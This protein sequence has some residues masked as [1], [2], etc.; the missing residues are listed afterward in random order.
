MK[1]IIAAGI[2]GCGR[3]EYLAGWLDY[4]QSAGRNVKVFN[5]GELMFEHAYRIGIELSREN[6]LNADPDLL[7]VLRSAVF[8]GIMAELS[9][10]KAQGLDSA[11]VCIHGFFFWKRRFQRSYDRFLNYFKPD[12][13]V[14]FIDDFRNISTRLSSRP[15]WQKEE[16]SHAEVL[17]WQNVEVEVTS[18]LAEFAEK[19]F[20]T[21]PTGQPTSTLY[22]LV[23]HPEIEPVYVAA[24]ISH[25]R[26]PEERE[27]ID[28]FIAG[29]DRYFT[30]FNP[31]TVEIIG[32]MKI[33]DISDFQKLTVAHHIVHRDL[34]WLVRS[35][36][37]VIVLMPGAPSPGVDH[38][39]HEAY[40]K[41]K[42]VWVVYLGE[43]TSPFV[44]YFNTAIFK[45]EKEF[46]DFLDKKYPGRKDLKW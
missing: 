16:L 12:M 18:G 6:I 45:G 35:A 34:Y 41:T 1:L 39:T 9:N 38:E 36:K 42:D 17:T 24:P 21:L 7:Q 26:K 27:I 19:P 15:Q 40:D 43:E 46:F 23:F 32:A 3:K 22:K 14:T 11:V 33:S 28:R 8:E 4:C 44:T 5:V 37:K 20:F 2:S 25:F 29:I 31:L 13:F 10:G 30:V